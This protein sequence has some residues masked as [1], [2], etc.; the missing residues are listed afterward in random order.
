[1]SRL[2]PFKR[3]KYRLPGGRAGVIDS[4]EDSRHGSLEWEMMARNVDIV[5]YADSCRWT[6]PADS[7]KT[8]DITD[9]SGNREG[10]R[11]SYYPSRQLT[12]NPLSGLSAAPLDL[13]AYEA[14]AH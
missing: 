9:S 6:A 1:M 7:A 3:T 11:I 8:D 5:I 4:Y 2:W 10:D 12:S 14:S 13:Y